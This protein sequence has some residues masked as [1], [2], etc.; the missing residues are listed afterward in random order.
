M[1]GPGGLDPSLAFTALL[2]MWPDYAL[3]TPDGGSSI[4]AALAGDMSAANPPDRFAFA[5]AWIVARR[6]V[7]DAV[8][9]GEDAAPGDPDP[10][11]AGALG[12]IGESLATIGVDLCRLAD[13]A[14]RI[15]SELGNRP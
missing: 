3:D 12:S 15:A 13:A 8:I 1:G 4:V 7:A 14:E 9:V 11:E 2:E 5:K 10:V 6:A